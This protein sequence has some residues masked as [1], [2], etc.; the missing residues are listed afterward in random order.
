VSSPLSS[1]AVRYNTSLIL[2][3][4][5]VL[6]PFFSQILHADHS[7]PSQIPLSPNTTAPFT[8]VLQDCSTTTAQLHNLPLPFEKKTPEN[9]KKKQKDIRSNFTTSSLL[10]HQLVRRYLFSCTVS[11][12]ITSCAQ[13][14]PAQQTQKSRQGT[15]EPP[16]GGHR[17]ARR[18]YGRADEA[19]LSNHGMGAP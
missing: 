8:G 16:N 12:L 19:C 6:P 17:C 9:R 1:S 4:T 2:P 13:L 7:G 11:S 14:L 3:I 15:G 10:P 18:V 5:P